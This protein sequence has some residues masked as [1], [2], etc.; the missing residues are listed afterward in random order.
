MQVLLDYRPAYPFQLGKVT[1]ADACM[2][3]CVDL[4]EHTL[5]DNG[6]VARG[7]R[8]SPLHHRPQL[9]D[10]Q[11]EAVCLQLAHCIWGVGWGGGGGGGVGGLA[12][13]G[14]APWLQLRA[15]HQPQL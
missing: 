3:A 6:A 8:G 12:P 15:A 10:V 4:H 2:H 1:K 9:P 14:S 7:L 13:G 5:A 11:G